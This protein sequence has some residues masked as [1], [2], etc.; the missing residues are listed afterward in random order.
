M[1]G[2]LKIMFEGVRREPVMIEDLVGMIEPTDEDHLIIALTL[3]NLSQ[4][5]SFVGQHPWGRSR[6]VNQEGLRNMIIPEQRVGLDRVVGSLEHGEL[7]PGERK[8]DLLVFPLPRGL[9]DTYTVEAELLLGGLAAGKTEMSPIRGR[10]RLNFASGEI[11]GA[12]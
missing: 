11:Q 2:D 10:L 1:V 3:E 8:P 5:H 12:P 9:S 4:S 7:R 6:L